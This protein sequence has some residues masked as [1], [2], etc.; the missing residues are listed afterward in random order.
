MIQV[1]HHK[2]DKGGIFIASENDK[3][4]GEMTWVDTGEGV[5][6]I[7][8]TAVKDDFRGRGVGVLL[9]EAGVHFA[10]ENHIKIL[11]LCPFAKAQ[12][13]RHKEWQDVLV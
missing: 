2:H 13:D 7:D 4:A 1:E 8:H 3:R 10:R 9:V 6:I 5:I 11:P 12:I